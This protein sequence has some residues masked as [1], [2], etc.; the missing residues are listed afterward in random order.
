MDKLTTQELFTQLQDRLVLDLKENEIACPKCKGLR[1]FYV[2]NGDKGYIETC[3]N[4]HTGKLY[5]CKYC[6]KATNTDY[7]DCKEASEERS[8]KW[9]S[10]Q[11]Q[12]DLE[13]FQKA[14][15]INYKDYTGYYLIDSDERLKTQ[16]DLEEWIYGKLVDGEDVTEYLWAV[17]EDFRMSIDLHEIISDKCEYGYED[18]YDFLNTNSPLLSQAQD[19]ISKWEDEQGDNLCTYSTTC[20]K[21]VIIKDLVDEI[22]NQIITEYNK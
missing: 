4:C 15:K 10:E 20:S 21:A 6:S 22:A 17:E 14:E 18:M 3:R 13:N 19:L 1:M 8:N 16:E 12:K 5:V 9:R 11:A 2:Q 7:C